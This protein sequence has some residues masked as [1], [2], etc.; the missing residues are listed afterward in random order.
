M[1]FVYFHNYPVGGHLGVFKTINKIRTQSIWNGMD[2]DIR[3]RV[4][5]C[6]EYALS[7]PAQNTRLGLLASE[8]SSRPMQKIFIDYVD[9]FTRSK[10]GNAVIL[11]CVDSF[12]KFA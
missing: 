5:S 6:R 7:K 12:S 9:R 3:V 11:V 10:S 2:N 4:R 8:V 1:V